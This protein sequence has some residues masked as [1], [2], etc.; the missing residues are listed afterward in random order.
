MALLSLDRVDDAIGQFDQSLVQN[1]NDLDVLCQVARLHMSASLSIMQKLME[2][3]PDSFQLHLLMGEVYFNNHHF[4]DSVKE[5]RAALAKRPDAPGIHFAMGNALRNLQKI[6]EAEVEFHTALKEN[7][8]DYGSNQYLGEFAVGRHE[9]SA[10]VPY[11]L[12]PVLRGPARLARTFCSASATYNLG[13]SQKAKA[14]TAGRRS[15]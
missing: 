12:L 2:I 5:Y 4:E 11:L 7:P 9:F 15:V 14:E 13:D 10:A 1:P 3:D 8:N 6:D